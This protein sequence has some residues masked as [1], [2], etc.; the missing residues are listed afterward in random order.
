[1]N[2]LFNDPHN[3]ISSD[4]LV[5]D[6]EAHEKQEVLLGGAS[7]LFMESQQMNFAN[8]RVIDDDCDDDIDM[9]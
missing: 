6:I 3:N 5:F 8:E 2:D 9:L 4:A 7:R 1:M